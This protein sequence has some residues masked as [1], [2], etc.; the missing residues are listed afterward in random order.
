MAEF[1]FSILIILALI[2]C[3][4][5][6]LAGLLGLGGGI[7]YIP[8]F[9]W[10]FEL[11]GVSPDILVHVAF[12]T[13]LAIILP[14]ALSSSLVHLRN[15]HLHWHLVFRLAIGSA[16][17]A[18]AGAK[19]A[20]ATPGLWLKA[21]FGLMLVAI[22]LRIFLSHPHLPEKGHESSSAGSLILVGLAGG[23]FA[24]F[25]GVSGA[26]VVLPLMILALKHPMHTA[27]GSS[28]ALMVISCLTG[29]A[30][31]MFHGWGNAA[32]PS[33]SLGYVNY[34]VVAVCA[35][36]TTLFARLGAQVA[37]RFS[38]DRLVKVFAVV[39]ILVGLRMLA[40]TLFFS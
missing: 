36:S 33:F 38:H 5:G 30:G 12:G 25:F 3:F 27:I 1:S 22:A 9:L 2:G 20:A 32:L 21:L 31:Y 26:V 7:I 23:F 10:A 28:S 35:P 40:T 19:I 13:S 6:F 17:G 29:M 4:A 15:G 39:L 8:L 11:F 18:L 16:L 24:A 37:H 14:T 34:L